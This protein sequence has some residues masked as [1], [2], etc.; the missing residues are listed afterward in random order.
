MVASDHRALQE[1]GEEGQI[2]NGVGEEPGHGWEWGR[3]G[4]DGA[5]VPSPGGEQQRVWGMVAAP[6]GGGCGALC[7]AIPL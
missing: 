4:C 5:A 1:E 7:S 2:R 6:D 3:R